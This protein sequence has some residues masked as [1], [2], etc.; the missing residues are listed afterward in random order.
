MK[1]QNDIATTRR[2]SV[3]A[4]HVNEGDVVTPGTPLVDIE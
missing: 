2:G 4:V 3:V 1:M